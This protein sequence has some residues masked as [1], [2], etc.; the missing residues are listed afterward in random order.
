MI[1]FLVFIIS[2]SATLITAMLLVYIHDDQI[3]TNNKP[4]GILPGMQLIVHILIYK[5]TTTVLFDLISNMNNC[6]K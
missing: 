6:R 1:W 4:N 3:S 2:V 5:H